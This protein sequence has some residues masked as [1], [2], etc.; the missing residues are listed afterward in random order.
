M[1]AQI[2]IIST[3]FS[4]DDGR[5]H[6]M[7]A[8]YG[9]VAPAGPRLFRSPPHPRIQ[10][11]HDSAEQAEHDAQLLR[12]YLAGSDKKRAKEPEQIVDPVWE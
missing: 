12:E 7:C 11:V 10:F 4:L 2:P 6:L 3:S 8:S 9:T 5:Y 1:N